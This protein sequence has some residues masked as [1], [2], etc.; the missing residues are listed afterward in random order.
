MLN[1]ILQLNT[2]LESKCPVILVGQP[3]SGK[4]KV[5]HTLARAVNMLNYKLYAPDHSKDELSTD[6]DVLFQS[7]QKLKVSIITLPETKAE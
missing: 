3:G 1:Q 7:K 5:F 6:R 2:A 4:T